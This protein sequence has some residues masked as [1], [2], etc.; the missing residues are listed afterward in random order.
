M[1]TTSTLDHNGKT[2]FEDLLC[3]PQF[4]QALFDVQAAECEHF[5]A[6]TRPVAFSPEFERKMELLLQAYPL[7]PQGV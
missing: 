3:S 4:R 2:S 7:C 6:D 1:N 5:A